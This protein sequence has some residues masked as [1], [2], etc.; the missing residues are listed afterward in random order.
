[1]AGATAT[2]RLAA[3]TEQRRLLVRRRLGAGGGAGVLATVEVVVVEAL[4]EED[5]VGDAK[6]AREGD[7][8]RGQVGEEGACGTEVNDSKRGLQGGMSIPKRLVTSPSIQTTKKAM[9]RPSALLAL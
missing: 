5:A 1:M 6:V 9:L 8:G 7:G 4:G 3:A 2:G